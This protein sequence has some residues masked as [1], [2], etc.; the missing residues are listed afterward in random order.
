[1]Q[2]ANK[3]QNY[4]ID[5]NWNFFSVQTAD[6]G[7]DHRFHHAAAVIRHRTFIEELTLVPDLGL[8][9][10]PGQTTKIHRTCDP[11]NISFVIKSLQ[12]AKINK[13][14]THTHSIRGDLSVFRYVLNSHGFIDKI[15]IL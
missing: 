7:P 13:T 5:C 4:F 9:A 1:M 8:A 6:L 2:I 12:N 11:R 14:H 15:H 10:T 3:I